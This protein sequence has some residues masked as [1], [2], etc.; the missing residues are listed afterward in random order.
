MDFIITQNGVLNHTEE[1]IWQANTD[2]TIYEVIRVMDGIALFLEDHFERLIS[3]VKI[4]G[5][6]LDMGFSEFRQN[7]SELT[8]LNNQQNGNV[9]F[10]FSGIGA[11]TQ[12]SFSFIPHSYPA[13]EDYQKGVATGLLFAERE[14]PNA[15]ILQIKVR[16]RAVRL[17][18]ENKLYEAL[19]VDRSGRITEGSRSN[20]FFV[21]GNKFYTAP[22][23]M[24]LVG[25]TRK[26]VMEC[27]E[28]LNFPVI[29]EAVSV[30][31]VGT[32]DAVFLTG[33]SPKVLP[34]HCIDTIQFPSKNPFVEQLMDRYDLMIEAYLEMHRT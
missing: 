23:A 28:E 9:K 31:D 12:W 16:E 1:N 19:L 29:E 24:V 5:L 22:S 33:T 6:Q 2:H 21:K 8:Q 18:A 3:S 25:V 13:S 4:S 14:N 7:I 32:F 10:A 20:V 27:L 26:K 30:S 11:E 15:K 17:I 34:V